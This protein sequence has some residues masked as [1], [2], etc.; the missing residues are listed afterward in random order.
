MSG[1]VHPYLTYFVMKECSPSWRNDPYR[2]EFN[3]IVFILEGSADYIV[4]DVHY[5]AKKGD[6]VCIQAQSL[7]SATT[8]GMVCVALDF[9]L[10]EDE[11][12]RLP[13]ISSRSD[14][15]DFHWMFQELNF[16]WLQKREGYQ[17]KG[18]AIFALILHKLMFEHQHSS[19]N[20][21]VE[22]MKR[23]IVAHYEEKLTVSA[24]ARAANL[25][26]I[27]GG[28][29]FKRLEGRSIA[30]FIQ[31]VRV[32]KAASLLHS[33]EYNIGEVADMT[34]FKDIY[35]FSNTFKR[36]MGVSPSSYKNGVPATRKPM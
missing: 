23:Y 30:E 3:A 22:A 13:V 1:A 19:G 35:Y 33:G 29:L 20:A 27:Y 11:D 4:D 17:M 18:Q 6:I 24:I 26:H 28:A 36:L 5:H 15:E 10:R 31:C 14:F 9:H 7:R 12:I 16:E 21:H 2:I 25:N 8:E 32:N 34:G